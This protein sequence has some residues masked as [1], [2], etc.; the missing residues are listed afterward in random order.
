M[1]RLHDLSGQLRT[2]SLAAL[3]CGND[4]IEIRKVVVDLLGPVCVD[5]FGNSQ[6]NWAV[7]P[8]SVIVRLIR[9]GGNSG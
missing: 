7:D 1:F 8:V 6:E 4:E 2:E 3:P 9:E 5:L